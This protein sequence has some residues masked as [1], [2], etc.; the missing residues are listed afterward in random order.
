MQYRLHPCPRLARLIEQAM[1]TPVLTSGLV[2]QE[3]GPVIQ[4]GEMR[5]GV[6]TE[7][8][9]RASQRES[10]QEGQDGSTRVREVSDH[11]SAHPRQRYVPGSSGGSAGAKPEDPPS[12]AQA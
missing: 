12:A 1:Q 7:P 5:L 4:Y 2:T 9:Q 10:P 8:A 11:S 3:G 6:G